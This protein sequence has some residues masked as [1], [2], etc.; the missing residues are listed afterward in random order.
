MPAHRHLDAFLK[1]AA[2]SGK[3][4]EYVRF[5]GFK[6]LYVRYVTRYIAGEFIH[7]VID[8]ANLE[9]KSPGKGA[10]GE[11]H[12]HLRLNYPECWLYVE[13]VLNP[14]FAKKLLKMGYTSQPIGMSECFYMP[15]VQMR[16]MYEQ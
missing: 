5:P 4:H 14:R 7:P 2:K 8:L 15:S 10:F 3:G 9:A 16:M 1:E 6:S 11:L 13:N 12:S